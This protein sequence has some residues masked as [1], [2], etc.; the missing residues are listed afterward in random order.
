MAVGRVEVTSSPDVIG[1]D[2]LTLEEAAALFKLTPEA[3]QTAAEGGD[4]PGR[5]I[6]KEWRFSRVALFT[7]LGR[8]DPVGHRKRR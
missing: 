2:V 7:W 5:R 8:G 1:D 4:V 3:V 6:G